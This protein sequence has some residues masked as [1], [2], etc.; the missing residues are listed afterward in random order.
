MPSILR[1][2]YKA[3]YNFSE[4][5]V[6][7]NEMEPN[8]APTDSR[9]RPDLRLLEET[10]LEEADKIMYSLEKKYIKLRAVEPVWFHLVQDPYT[11][12]M[13]YKFTNEYWACKSRQDWTKSPQSLFTT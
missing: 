13:V 10:K 12:E 8:V 4:F 3:M 6:Q 7:L 2:K 9:L 1:P 5:T 11:N